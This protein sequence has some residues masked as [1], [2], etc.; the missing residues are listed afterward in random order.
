MV[1]LSLRLYLRTT[2][3]Y[4]RDCYLFIDSN[5]ANQIAFFI[6]SFGQFLINSRD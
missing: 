4:L 3:M 2:D 1:V 5:V 6:L